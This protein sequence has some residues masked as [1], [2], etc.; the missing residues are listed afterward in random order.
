MPERSSPLALLAAH[1]QAARSLD[2]A[3][4]PGSLLQQAADALVQTCGESWA[5][6]WRTSTAQGTQDH[7]AIAG[8]DGPPGPCPLDLASI[9]GSHDITTLQL[10]AEEVSEGAVASGQPWVCFIV[11][12]V[13][14]GPWLVMAFGTDGQSSPVDLE[15]KIGFGQAVAA[16][17]EA[18]EL[19][20]RE[21]A[22]RTDVE[23]Q[24]R[25]FFRLLDSSPA[26]ILVARGSAHTVE[27]MN[28]ALHMETAGQRV[29]GR[30]FADAFPS[31]AAQGVLEMLE[32]AHSR[33][34]PVRL[35]EAPIRLR[36]DDSERTR[37][38]DIVI[39][40][41]GRDL[42]RDGTMVHAVD[43]TDKVRARKEL[44]ASRARFEDLVE[45]VD[46]IVW[47]A[48]PT[49][50]RFTFL[51]QQTRRLWDQA[52]ED[53]DR[54]EQL[55]SHIDPDDLRSVR[56][57]REIGIG[58]R[59]NWEVEYRWRTPQDDWRWLGERARVLQDETGEI[60]AIRGLTVDVT[61]RREAERERER[62]Q[63]RLQESQRLESMGLLAGGIAHDFNNLLTAMM[64]NASLALSR[65]PEGSPGQPQIEALVSAAQRAS[66]LTRQMLAY[67]GRGQF[68]VETTHVSPRIREFAVLLEA[69][70]PKR[71]SLHLELSEDL[72][73]VR[74]D[75]AQFQQLVMNLVINAAESI[76]KG[77]GEVRVRSHLRD[78]DEAAL[79]ELSGA[80][81]LIA[82]T[83]VC[84]E[85]SDT[86]Q[87]MDAETVQRIFDPFFS[88][89][90]GGTGL[91]LA[92][93]QG[94][95][96]GHGGVIEV[97]S[98][99]GEGTTFRAFFPPSDEESEP[100]PP[101]P[102]LRPRELGAPE[103][104]DHGGGQVLVIDDELAVRATVRVLL[105]H[106]GFQVVDAEDG[107]SG[108]SL[109]DAYGPEIDIV[110]LDLTM[111]GMRGEEVFEILRARAPNL[112]IIVSSGYSASEVEDTAFTRGPTVFLGKPYTAE[113]LDDALYIVQRKAR[114]G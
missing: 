114:R 30:P 61:E 44:E 77:S 71:V 72:P 64:G 63:R 102:S 28:R 49:F 85:V 48:D 65:L 111:P 6:F 17:I 75:V 87:G 2:P 106:F 57:I 26:F 82:G 45:S 9:T 10:P 11:V 23:A 14:N 55:E 7:A 83:Y 41:L 24:G 19:A 69:A 101:Q 15:I 112:P 25:R 81:E 50:A 59:R 93:V 100:P 20:E 79:A 4:S 33:G 103:G 104:Q 40:P 70:L 66:E 113:E 99:T 36:D 73:L 1:N 108:L 21:R 98:R 37:S 94:I 46:G 31:I 5:G 90:V 39:Q 43:V 32:R 68:V 12:R 60:T 110:M 53:L 29:L 56:A 107:R 67:S 62:I 8:L 86:G 47:E 88:R 34:A 80:E 58:A 27:F 42:P 16:L 13:G 109:W 95:V 18:A 51:S 89:K 92:A 52:P 35:T 74:V 97:E 22:T 78:L 91:G 3:S 105:E 54:T 38:F 96:R 76:G 84:I